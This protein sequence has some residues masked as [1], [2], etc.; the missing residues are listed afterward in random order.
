VIPA[1]LLL[2]SLVSS[3]AIGDYEGKKSSSVVYMV[4]MAGLSLATFHFIK[5]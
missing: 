4:L 5:F 2:Y 3:A 1:Y